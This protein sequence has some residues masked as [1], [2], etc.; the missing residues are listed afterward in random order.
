MLDSELRDLTASEPLTVQEEYKM[1]RELI[2]K[3]LIIY[4]NSQHLLRGLAN[5]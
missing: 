1:Q 3:Q 2:S 5:G 4:V